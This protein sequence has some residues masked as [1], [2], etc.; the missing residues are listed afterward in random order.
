MNRWLLRCLIVGSLF[1]PGLGLARTDAPDDES[2]NFDQTLLLKKVREVVKKHYPKAKVELK[3][4]EIRFDYKTRV[5]KIHTANLEGVWQDARDERGPQPGGV[6]GWI[7]LSKGEVVGMAILPQVFDLHYYKS[8][9]MGHYDRKLDCM[10]DAE[11]RYPPG[12]AK[13]FVEGI[14]E[15]IDQFQKY[16]RKKEK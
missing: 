8:Y 10:V 16:V 12:E 3:D 15:I 5:F 2:D 7:K 11:V 1:L 4:G 14:E 13:V 6:Y 9:R